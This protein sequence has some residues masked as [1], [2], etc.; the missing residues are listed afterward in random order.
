MAVTID[1]VSDVICPWCFI[2]KRRLERALALY[3]GGE[4]PLAHWLPFEL[5]PQMPEGGMDRRTYRSAKFGSWERS[6]ALDAQVA[7][8]GREEGIAFDFTAVARTPNTRA[9]HRLIWLAGER[10]VQDGVVEALFRGYFTGGKD[11]SDPAV[12]A[13]V[14]TSGGLDRGEVD[15]LLAGDAGLAAVLALEEEARRRGF[16]GVPTFIINGTPTFSGAQ[17]VETFLKAFNDAAASDGSPFVS[18]AG[19]GLDPSGKWGAC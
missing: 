10:G 17:Q 2:G 13:S 9:A 6:L 11:L 7:S 12:L 8:S 14:A 5:N 3:E 16:L 19:C 4:K 1:I 15:R 18:G